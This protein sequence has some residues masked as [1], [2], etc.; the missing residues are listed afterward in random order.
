MFPAEVS[1][2]Y[3]RALQSLCEEAEEKSQASLQQMLTRTAAIGNHCLS[4]WKWDTT[5]ANVTKENILEGS[6]Y[7]Q[8]FPHLA[9]NEYMF[10]A[11]ARH[12]E[13]GGQF[14]CCWQVRLEALFT[15]SAVYI[16]QCTCFQLAA[17]KRKLQLPS[18]QPL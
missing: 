5:S 7:V 2:F 10:L 11:C 14:T 18:T 15:F 17:P 3:T 6:L 13:M 12:P 16:F 4:R 9:S 1:T 8:T